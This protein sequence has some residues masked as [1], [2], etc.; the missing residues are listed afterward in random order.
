MTFPVITPGKKV[1][2]K[3]V[4]LLQLQLE[5]DSG[6]SL[7]DEYLK[8]SLVDLNRAGLPLMEL[9]F[10]PDLETGEEAASLVKELMLILRRLQTCS[11]KMEGRC[12]NLMLAKYL[13]LFPFRGSIACG[14]QHIHSPRK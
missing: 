2:Y 11:C 9:V 14:C 1:Y 3:S 10:A 6:K 7:H 13:N 4:N 5:Q 12:S 8:R